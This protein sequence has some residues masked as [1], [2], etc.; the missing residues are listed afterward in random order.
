MN[1]RWA[2]NEA[3]VSGCYLFV[4]CDIDDKKTV[5]RKEEEIQM[6]GRLFPK[7]SYN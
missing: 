4:Y 3:E 6:T 5:K 1:V 7:I 2:S